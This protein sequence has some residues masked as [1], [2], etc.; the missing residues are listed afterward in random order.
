M[1]RTTNNNDAISREQILELEKI[2]ITLVEAAVE[3]LGGDTRQVR[4][5]ISKAKRESRGQVFHMTPFHAAEVFTRCP[6]PHTPESLEHKRYIQA[7]DRIIPNHFK[8][9]WNLVW[10]GVQ[11]K[12]GSK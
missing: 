6:L 10:F 11:P 8:T 5:I 9:K 3:I 1:V 2:Y 12:T 7:A 4:P